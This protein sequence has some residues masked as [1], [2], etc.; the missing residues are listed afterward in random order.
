MKITKAENLSEAQKQS[1]IQLWNNEY[2]LQ[3]QHSDIASFDEY[4]SSKENLQHYLLTDDSE[5]IK[6]WLATFTRDDEKWFALLVD[7]SEQKK[8]YGTMLLNKVKEFENEIN[9]WA[10]DRETD[11]KLNGE[12]YLS[13]IKFYLKNDFEVLNEVRLETETMSAV[14]IKWSNELFNQKSDD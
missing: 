9:G 12:T 13:P 7:G 6:G 3:I 14:K 11:V 1:I 2:P 8:G 5:N 10:I 4:L